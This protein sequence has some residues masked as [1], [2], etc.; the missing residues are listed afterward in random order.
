MNKKRFIYLFIILALAAFLVLDFRNIKDFVKSSLFSPSKEI[1]AIETSLKLTPYG[2]RVF[3]ASSPSLISDHSE[4]E[5]KCYTDSDSPE[6]S[7][8]GCYTDDTI[9]I[10]NVTSDELSGITESTSAHELLHAIWA[11]L[12]QS[13]KSSLTPTLES[14]YDSSDSLFKKSLE[15][16]PDSQRLEEIYVRSATQISALPDTLETHFAKF[17]RDQDSVVAF[18]SD[19]ITPFLSIEHSLETLER[20]LSDIN[21][22]IEAKTSEYESRSETFL[23]NLDNFNSCASTPGCFSATPFNHERALLLSEQDSLNSLYAEINSL[24]DTYN[25]KV[26]L[27]NSNILHNKT[28][29]KELN[30]NKPSKEL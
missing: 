26:E 12:P 27:Y 29:E 6:S 18:Y 3:R 24:I 4:F 28:L 5:S 7:I 11:R 21:S 25:S 1:S 13:E 9:F 10:Y 15:N 17:F 14:V 8:L 30:P 23:S 2:S 16:Y 22:Q 19:Y 20:E